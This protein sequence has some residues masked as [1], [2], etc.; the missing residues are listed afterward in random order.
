MPNPLLIAQAAAVA[1]PIIQDVFKTAKRQAENAVKDALKAIKCALYPCRC[2]VEER[3]VAYVTTYDTVVKEAKS[4]ADGGDFVTA[5]ALASAA[6]TL[7]EKPPFSGYLASRG[8]DPPHCTWGSGPATFATRR[9][10]ADALADGYEMNAGEQLQRGEGGTHR[11][12]K[13]GGA[14]GAPV[15]IGGALLLGALVLAGG[16]RG[17]GRKNGD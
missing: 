13:R 11:P 4:A 10:L 5:Y 1:A 17:G 8:S 3:S 15:L 16:R 6:A 2:V 14:I 9:I 7:S 12:R